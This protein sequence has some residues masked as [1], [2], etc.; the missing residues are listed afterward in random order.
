MTQRV[1]DIIQGLMGRFNRHKYTVRLAFGQVLIA[2]SAGTAAS[3]RP[4]HKNL[5]TPITSRPFRVIGVP[6]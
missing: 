5:K 1:K 6:N 4:A 3:L 2:A